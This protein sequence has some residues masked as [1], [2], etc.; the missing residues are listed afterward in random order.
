MRWD[1]TRRAS[2]A[3]RAA[4]AE[5]GARDQSEKVGYYA[6]RA[7]RTES[8]GVPEELPTGSSSGVPD[9]LDALHTESCTTGEGRGRMSTPPP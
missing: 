7:Y 4:A 5:L 3:L 2:S 9:A 6:S 1:A 8:L